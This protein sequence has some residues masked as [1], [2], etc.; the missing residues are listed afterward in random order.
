MWAKSR[1]AI[2]GL[3]HLGK[4]RMV[5][6]SRP[7]T[8]E[9]DLFSIYDSAKHIFAGQLLRDTRVAERG[10]CGTPGGPSSSGA[11]RSTPEASSFPGWQRLRRRCNRYA[12]IVLEPILV[13]VLRQL[14]ATPWPTLAVQTLRDTLFAYGRASLGVKLVA[15]PQQA[16]RLAKT[17]STSQ[18]GGSRS[19]TASKAMKSGPTLAR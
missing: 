1:I 14:L 7:A 17:Q 6:Q 9:Q 10:P 13:A 4:C 5:Q 16:V 2:P 19:W 3:L 18:Y 15:Y 8:S 11:R 12:S